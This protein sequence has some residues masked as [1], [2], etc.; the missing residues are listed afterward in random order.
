M[1]AQSGCREIAAFLLGF[2]I[3]QSATV[4]PPLPPAPLDDERRT[5]NAPVTA[6]RQL[7]A[8]E[9][10][11]KAAADAA[12]AWR[13]GLAEAAAKAEQDSKVRSQ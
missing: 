4:C 3:A 6:A 11:D 13:R 2:I 7:I 10:A 9:A 1:A 5:T 8:R 12:E